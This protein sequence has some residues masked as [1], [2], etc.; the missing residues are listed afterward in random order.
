MARRTDDIVFGQVGQRLLHR[1]QQGRP[2]NAAFQVFA[3]SVGDDASPEFVGEAALDSV[4]TT[5]SAIAG[6]TLADPRRI[7]IASTAG[8]VRGR[9]YLISDDG[10]SEWVEPL[11]IAADH[12]RIRDRLAGSYTAAAAFVST[13]LAADISDAWVADRTNLSDLA[14]PNPDYRVRWLIAIDDQPLVAYSYFDL[15]RSTF[16]HAIDIADIAR[17]MPGVV[18]MLTVA[19][20]L[21]Q[22]HAI[23]DDAWRTVR[24][25]LAGLDV[26]DAALREDES[27]DEAV[28]LAARL[29]L[30]EGGLHPRAFSAAEFLMMAR[31]RYERFFEKHFAARL[32][33]PIASGSDSGGRE[34]AGPRLWEK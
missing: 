10:Q 2:S 17:R 33:V 21:D 26:N 32:R 20:R 6:A 14:D 3:E 23:I 28:T 31:E 5:L 24:L 16:E 1:V 22:A 11:V 18:E 19:D 25:D 27:V 8:I 7:P 15:V 9:K 30:A 12:V 13:Y 34:R 4:D 29:L